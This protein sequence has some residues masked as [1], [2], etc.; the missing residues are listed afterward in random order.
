MSTMI[1]VRN[2]PEDLHRLLKSQAA[3][4]GC[5]LSD[6]ALRVLE[7]EAGRRSNEN[8]LAEIL[9]R[10]VRDFGTTAAEL[11]ADERAAR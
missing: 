8:V 9:R 6:F 7:R 3:A 10:P 1:Q 5:T 2:I 4:E 11:L